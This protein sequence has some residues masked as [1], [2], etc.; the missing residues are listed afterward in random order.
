MDSAQNGHFLSDA[1]TLSSG[2]KV[3]TIMPAIGGI[4]IPSKSHP[5]NERP[6]LFAVKPMRVLFG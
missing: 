6:A 3:R 1:T 2:L 5:K 4:T